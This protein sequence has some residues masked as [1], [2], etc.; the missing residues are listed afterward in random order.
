MSMTREELCFFLA[1]I[2]HTGVTEGIT[3]DAM[4]E[5]AMEMMTDTTDI[6][7]TGKTG[8]RRRTQSVAPKIM[9]LPGCEAPTH[10]TV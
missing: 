1:S 10:Y 3:F 9:Q 8:K 2:G 7:K 4:Y 6:V 5:R